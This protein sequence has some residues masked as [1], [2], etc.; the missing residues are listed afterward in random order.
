MLNMRQRRWIELLSDYHPGKVNVVADALSKK[1]RLGPLMVWALGM[2]VQTSMKSCIIKAQSEALKEENLE[3]EKLYNAGQK[4]EVW[5]VGVRYLKG[6][7]WI[8]KA[9]NM[10]N[11]IL[12]EAHR[13]RYSIHIGADKMHQDV[14]EYY[15]WLGMKKDIALYMGKYL[16]CVKVKAE[17]QKTFGLLQQPEILSAHFLPIREDYK[18]ERLSRIYINDIVS[19]H[20][21]PILIISDRDDRFTLHFWKLLH[22]ALG[23]HLDLSTAYH[24]WMDG[25]SERTI[26]TME[27]KLKACV[28]DS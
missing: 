22:K 26:Q 21:T 7:A 25:W 6:R 24:P 4:F 23:T 18:M 15:W 3:T 14:K 19:C 11:V 9:N 16:T 27:D 10:R 12:D 2:I 28:I 5:L 8:P 17:Y 20:G 1:E 13:S